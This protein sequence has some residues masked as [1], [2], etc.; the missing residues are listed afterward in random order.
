M[1][2]SERQRFRTRLVCVPAP[3]CAGNGW[4]RA[5][6]HAC[7]CACVRL[8]VCV[9]VCVCV[10][11]CTCVLFYLFLLIVS[12]VLAPVNSCESASLGTTYLS[13]Q[14]TCGV[15]TTALVTPIG[16]RGNQT[17]IIT[18]KTVLNGSFLKTAGMTITAISPKISSAPFREVSRRFEVLI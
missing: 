7:L 5:C 9:F 18:E 13:V 17:T 16:C 1:D 14:V 8:C 10:L 3:V 11:E 12:V 15:T 6:L 2:W 4:S